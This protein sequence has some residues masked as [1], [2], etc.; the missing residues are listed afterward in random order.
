MTEISDD[1]AAFKA[2]LIK[3]LGREGA[4]HWLAYAADVLAREHRIAEAQAE[5]KAQGPAR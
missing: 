5:A 1:W 2:R 3:S 4:A